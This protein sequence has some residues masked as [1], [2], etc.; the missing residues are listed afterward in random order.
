MERFTEN[1]M[2]ASRWLLAPVY[3]GLSLGL[4]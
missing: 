1:L 4:L 3:I 2:Y